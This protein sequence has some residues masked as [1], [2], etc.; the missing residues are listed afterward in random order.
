[1]TS[2]IGTTQGNRKSVS[3]TGGGN[4]WAWCTERTRSDSLDSIVWAVSFI[5]AGAVI[6]AYNLGVPFAIPTEA[7]AWSVFFLGAAAFVLIEVAV[8]LFVPAYRTSVVGELIWAGVLIALG[9]G[10]LAVLVPLILIAIGVS[11]VRDILRKSESQW[12]GGQ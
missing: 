11:I 5:W 7:Q 4:E 9:T 6:L 1:M 8:R 10:S 12:K 2:E 3:E